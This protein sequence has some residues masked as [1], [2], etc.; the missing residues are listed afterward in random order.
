MISD[1][2][3]YSMAYVTGYRVCI[4][5]IYVYLVPYP[6][7]RYGIGILFAF[8]PRSNHHLTLADPQYWSLIGQW[9]QDTDLWL[10]RYQLAHV[11]GL[12]CGVMS[13]VV[14]LWTDVQDGQ[15]T[16]QS[17]ALVTWPLCSPLIGCRAGCRRAGGTGWRGTP[18]RCSPPRSRAWC[19]SASLSYIAAYWLNPGTKENTLMGHFTFPISPIE[20]AQAG[21]FI[22]RCLRKC[23][24]AS[25]TCGDLQNL[26]L[27][28][29]AN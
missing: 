23:R 7:M 9:Q 20:S 16:N 3:F 22:W 5:D 12:V 13:V 6:E 26:W 14:I 11:L 25:N 1:I 2:S 18:S 29:S 10:V 15:V 8:Y 4:R 17:P 27:I 21:N 24:P 28:I 19:R